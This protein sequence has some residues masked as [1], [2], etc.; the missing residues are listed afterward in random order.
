MSSLEA[1]PHSCA[2]DGQVTFLS[3]PAWP[4]KIPSCIK[5]FLLGKYSPVS[6]GSSQGV[7]FLMDELNVLSSGVL[8]VSRRDPTQRGE[9]QN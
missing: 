9:M 2:G 8:R 7:A 6:R 3:S 4:K 5:N 1:A